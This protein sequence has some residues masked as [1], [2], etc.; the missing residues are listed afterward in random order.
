[1]NLLISSGLP[2]QLKIY[3][4]GQEAYYHYCMMVGDYKS[5]YISAAH[6]SNYIEKSLPSE[7]QLALEARISALDCL[8]RAGSRIDREFYAI[9]VLIMIHNLYQDLILSNR[10]SDFPHEERISRL[11]AT[12]VA[13]WGNGTSIDKLLISLSERADMPSKLRTQAEAALKAIKR[14]IEWNQKVSSPHSEIASPAAM[15]SF[16]SLF[17]K[18]SILSVPYGKYESAQQESVP[19]R[20]LGQDNEISSQMAKLSIEADK[21][22]SESLGCRFPRK[23]A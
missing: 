6:L 21:L 2:D 16:T 13:D 5:A 19:V 14:E 1:M 4:Q 10:Y 12:A 18:F 23:G 8:L 17:S 22:E 7:W 3:L 11:W 15:S 9:K 20:G